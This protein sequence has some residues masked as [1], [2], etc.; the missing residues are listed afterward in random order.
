MKNIS[1]KFDSKAIIKLLGVQLYDTPMAMLRENVQNGFD[2]VKERQEKDKDYKDPCVRITITDRKIVVSDNGIGMNQDNLEQ[3]FWTAGKSGKNNEDSRKAGVVGHFGI[4]ALANFGVCSSLDVDTRKIG[5]DTRYHSH[6]ESE[7]LDG[8]QITIDETPDESNNY[9]TTITAILDDEHNFVVEDAKNYLKP[10]VQYVDIPVYL[11]D[12]LISQQ[13]MGIAGIPHDVYNLNGTYENGYTSFTYRIVFLTYHPISP[14]IEITGIKLYGREEPGM[15]YLSKSKSNLFGLNNGFGLA[16]LNVYSQFGFGGFANFSFLE[17]TAGREAIAKT[18]TERIQS[19]LNMVEEFWANSIADYSLADDYRDFLVYVS[20]HFSKQLAR[21]IRIS[22][23][24][25]GGGNDIALGDIKPEDNGGFYKGQDTKILETHKTTGNPVYRVSQEN[26]RRKIQLQYLKQIGI[27]ELNDSVQIIHEYSKREIKSDEFMFLAEVKRV[28]ED[29]YILD[30]F[31]VRL[32]DISHNVQIMVKKDEGYDFVIYI[33]RQSGDV[34][35][36][37]KMYRESYLYFTPM[38]KDYVRTALYRQFAEYIPKDKQERAAYIDAAYQRRKEELIIRETDVSDDE[39]LFKQLQKGEITTNQFLERVKKIHREKQEQ[40][41]SQGSVGR[42]ENVVKTAA[43]VTENVPAS[44]A[45]TRNEQEDM[46]QPPILELDN[47][48]NKK[49]LR[50][51]YNTPILHY[52][53]L[54]ISLSTNMDRDFRSFFMLPHTTK[55][56][57]STHRIIYIFTEYTG[58]VSLY[59]EMELKKKLANEQTGGR[60]VVS[61]TIITKR[62]IF[63]PIPEEIMS[64]FDFQREQ[65]LIFYV[66][67]DKVNG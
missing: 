44:S 13:P 26:P 10:F 36:I 22:A 40:A 24:G 34:D 41:V 11:N 37:C 45:P 53:R 16:N 3:N 48:T 52:H 33:F 4:G 28:I 12:E 51:E 57:W 5:E 60:S 23:D 15:L 50:T 64:Y 6:A 46:P 8:E 49:L 7:K 55:V 59:Y 31:D 29:D 61:T 1:L 2:A 47:S 14:Q 67:F 43:L 20:N 58:S 39:F 18:C 42:V 38:V 63:V 32:A 66:H 27:K 62:K 21:N 17:P 65:E 25:I 30:N 9:G 56:I 19:L 35:Q 54:F